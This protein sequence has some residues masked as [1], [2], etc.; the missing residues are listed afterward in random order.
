[1]SKVKAYGA[2]AS[3]ANLEALDIERR[4][5]TAD[6]VKRVMEKY[7]ESEGSSVVQVLDSGPRAPAI[8][9]GEGSS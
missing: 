8:E 3:D 6:D 5:I 2:Q 1:M 9:P 4:E 7:L